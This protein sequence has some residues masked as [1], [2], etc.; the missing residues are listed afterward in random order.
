MKNKI[1]DVLI[2]GGGQAGLLTGYYLKNKKLSFLIVD[3]N[4]RIGDSWRKRYDSLRLLT[5]RA[6]D[7][8]PG[9]KLEGD[10]NDYPTK[11]EI[12]DYLEK[13]ANYFDLP[14]KL[15]TTIHKL[16]K[17]DDKFKAYSENRI[18]YS[19]VVIIATGAFQ[20][21]FL[22]FKSN[23]KI[24]TFQIH[25]ANYKNPKQ[26]PSGRVLIVGGGYSGS[27]ITSELVLTHSVSF[28]TKGRLIRTSRYDLLY[29]IFLKILGLQIL[30]K[31]VNIFSIKKIDEPNLDDLLKNKKITLK[32]ELINTQGE[33]FYFKDSTND[34]FKAVV[35][36]TGFQLDYSWIK[37]PKAFDNKKRPIHINGVSNVEG[38]Y[39]IYPEEDYGF[40]KDLPKKVEKIIKAL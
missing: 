25:S 13:Y 31:I 5:L 20:K 1:Y 22:P 30:T 29:K 3:A 24:K 32:P 19:K 14:V 33:R 37:I 26:I 4:K 9:M 39:F 17:Q 10:P 11:D 16:I 18:F 34:T 2:I 8:L 35:W 21:H 6:N 27:Q 23:F 12:A 36:A 15:N 7:S 40:I 28:S 38:L